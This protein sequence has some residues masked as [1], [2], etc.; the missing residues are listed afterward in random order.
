MKKTIFEMS[1]WKELFDF[2]E[3]KIT[4]CSTKFKVLNLRKHEEIKVNEKSTKIYWNE[5]K[6][7]RTEIL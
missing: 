5:E 6:E 3:M 4:F 2:C 1:F 7:S